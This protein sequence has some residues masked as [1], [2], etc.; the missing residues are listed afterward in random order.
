[1]WADHDAEAMADHPPTVARIPGG[2]RNQPHSTP[3]LESECDPALPDEGCLFRNA[4]RVRIEEHRDHIG[5]ELAVAIANA[6]RSSR[7]TQ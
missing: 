7:P 2:S 3:S 5:K 6:A 1:M 4:F